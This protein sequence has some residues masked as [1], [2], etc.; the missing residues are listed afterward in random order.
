MDLNHHV[1]KLVLGGELISEAVKEGLSTK[2]GAFQ[3]VLDLGTGTGVWAM[4]F[5]DEWVD[6]GVSVVGND[7]SP[8]QP[9]VSSSQGVQQLLLI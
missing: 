4:D 1:W 5:A 9:R 6:E 7:L 3:R 2:R 8:I